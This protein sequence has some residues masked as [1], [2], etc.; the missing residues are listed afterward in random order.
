MP[1]DPR[2]GIELLVPG[3]SGADITFNE[4]VAV[5]SLINGAEFETFEQNTPPGSP[6]NGD[7]HFTGA[8]PTGDW[9]NEGDKIAA[10]Y[11]GWHFFAPKPGMIGYDNTN[12]ELISWDSGLS[13][14]F[15]V[16]D[17]W[18]STEHFT[19]KRRFETGGSSTR[20]P[21]YSKTVTSTTI[22]T[23]ATT[24]FLSHGITTIDWAYQVQVQYGLIQTDGTVKIGSGMGGAVINGVVDVNGFQINN[25]FITFASTNAL[26]G[27][28]APFQTFQIEFR[29][30]YCK[31]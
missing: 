15:P 16:Q 5:L 25:Q 10:Y 18:S 6:V 28:S 13:T 8:S 23:P 29:L 31:E 4:A 26:I 17:R 22:T 19:G 30:E 7:V 11:N 27:P 14:W 3:Q 12:F 20:K 21:V 24:L 9:I 1:Q 2:H